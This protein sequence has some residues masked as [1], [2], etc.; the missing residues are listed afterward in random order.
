MRFFIKF[1]L[2]FSLFTSKLV[3]VILA[4]IAGA[5]PPTSA[6]PPAQQLILPPQLAIST[7]L[8]VSLLLLLQLLDPFTSLTQ[9]WQG[10]ATGLPFPLSRLGLGA[11]PGAF[12][13]PLSLPVWEGR[14]GAV[15][16]LTGR[17]GGSR[18]ALSSF[19]FLPPPPPPTPIVK[20][21]GCKEG[22]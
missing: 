19:C 12:Y 18:A 11:A 8:P 1:I 20:V 15:P 7:A 14:E 10:P 3:V 13:P 9:A 6:C 17:E 21:S 2:C 4:P 16:L 5:L 22:R